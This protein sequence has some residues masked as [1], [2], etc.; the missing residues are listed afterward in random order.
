MRKDR[1]RPGVATAQARRHAGLQMDPLDLL[2]LQLDWGAVDALDE[3]PLD[4]TR[5]AARATERAPPRAAGAAAPEVTSGSAAAALR[6]VA[7]PPLSPA[8]PPAPRGAPAIRGPAAPPVARAQALA[9]AA[10]TLD[11]LRDA[12]AAFD[13]LSIRETATR[14]VFADGNPAAPLMLIGEAPGEEEDAQGK[15][16]VGASGRLLD[17][18]LASIGLDRSGFY[19]TNIVVWRPPGNRTPSDAEVAMSL[20]FTLR[21][22]ALVRPRLVM[23]V[24]A[25]A[26]R[27]LLRTTEGITRLRGRRTTIEVPGMP[28]PVPAL[29]VLHPAYLLRQPQAKALHW[30]DLIALRRLLDELRAG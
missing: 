25:I 18:M 29:P 8:R 11:E 9:D 14:L 10:N 3:A 19:I 21:H 30:Q 24:G 23:P 22:I 17:R 2:A 16:F 28:D 27:A 12:M 26:A 15:P 13:G 5:P 4:R 20:P 6:P 1:A 7:A